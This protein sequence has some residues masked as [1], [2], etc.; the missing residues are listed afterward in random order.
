MGFVIFLAIAFVIGMPIAVVAALVRSQENARDLAATRS[1]LMDLAR[2]LDRLRSEV[3]GLR[4]AAAAQVSPARVQPTAEEKISTD[5]VA[6]EAPQAPP[7][8]QQPTPTREFMAHAEMKATLGEAPKS[9]GISIETIE[10]A[11]TSRWLVW[12]GAVSIALGGTFLVKYAID[13]GLLGPT[14]RVTLGFILGIA[15]AIGGEWLRQRPLQRA[16]ANIRP[17]HVPPALSASGVFVAF[18]SLYAAYALYN[19][20]PP[21]VAFFA[22]AAVALVAVGLSLLQGQFVAWLGVF[23]SFL[24]PALVQTPNPSAFGFVVYLLV[25]GGACLAVA[26]YQAWWWFGF[27]TLAGAAI[28]PALWMIGQW[29]S[30]DEWPFGLYLL[31]TAAAF[32]LVPP[33][34]ETSDEVQDWLKEW[35]NLDLPTQLIWIA[36]GVVIAALTAMVRVSHYSVP[37]LI[38]FGAGVLLALI[39]GRRE[40]RFDGFAVAAAAATLYMLA[41]MPVPNTVVAP[42][43]LPGAPFIPPE[44]SFFAE[45]NFIFGALFAAGGFIALW[46]GKRAAIWAGVS[47]ATPVLL[48]V[49]A[50]DRIVDFNVDLAWAGLAIALAAPNLFAAE[51]VE[52][53]RTTRGLEI[54]LGFYAAAVTACL[55]L[56][57]AMA[58]REAWLTV[59]LAIE[60]PVLGLIGKRVTGKA[61]PVIAAIVSAIVLVRLLFNYNIF[62]Y[63][64]TAHLGM[65]WIVYGY[66][67]PAVAFFAAAR[68]FRT[69]DVEPLAVLLRAGGVAFSVLF[70]SLQIRVLIAGSLDARTYGLLEQSLHSIAWLSIGTGLALYHRRTED[71]VSFYGSR[72]LLTSAAAQIALLQLLLSNP[73]FSRQFVG[74]YPVVNVLF[75]A[76]AVPAI[77]AFC[78]A[79]SE[80]TRDQ[81]LARISAIAGFVLVF[82]YISLEVRR[83]Y[84]GPFLVL[85]TPSDAEMY[86]YSAVWLCYAGILLGL[87]I[88]LRR[89]FLRHAAIAVLLVAVLKVFLFDMAGLTGLYRVVS[90][91]GLGLSLVG[92]GYLYQRF[93]FQPS[94]GGMA[95]EGS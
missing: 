11:L 21:L 28:W 73:L 60:L 5:A 7:L 13:Q 54:S 57:A 90:F 40:A 38:F 66:G 37:A 56:A 78:V 48:L 83:A 34:A 52:R 22:L 86:A 4:G 76:Y 16:I 31:I 70:V 84:Q 14:A 23:G 68:L 20:L 88:S 24:T 42:P 71:G 18:A 30:G 44:L 61:I 15:L 53:Y 94:R 12:L 43:A 93:V 35:E 36:A 64:L 9:A 55:S 59:A 46:G 65:S 77:F 82:L 67:I 87:G 63:P 32:F 89:T 27:A 51:R 79:V 6:A 10:E 91:M 47:A 85:S 26:R 29:T 62:Q 17:N 80:H 81:M 1:A 33:R 49:I 69:A 41:G 3:E 58:I 45:T 8:Q 19:L 25:V 74:E 92:I 72:I 39:A 2:K 50:Y 95:A 75:L